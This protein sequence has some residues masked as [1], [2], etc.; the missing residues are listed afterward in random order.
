MA[1]LH[2]RINPRSAEFETNRA[3]M[4]EQVDDLRAVVDVIRQGGGEKARARHT[5]RGKLLP[6]E[7]LDAL[8]SR[9]TGD[10]WRRGEILSRRALLATN[11]SE[12]ELLQIEGED[13]AVVPCVNAH[14]SWVAGLARIVEEQLGATRS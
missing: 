3:H 14:E 7:R 10:Y 8:L 1:T 2:T 13:F 6:R 12:E 11:E 4:Q 5:A 9:V